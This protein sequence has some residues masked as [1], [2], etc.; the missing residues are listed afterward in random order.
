MSDAEEK[1][2][3]G[4]DIIGDTN[5]VVTNPLEKELCYRGW[6]IAGVRLGYKSAI[7]HM[8]LKGPPVS[9]LYFP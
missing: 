8:F 6:E 5:F 2:K 3:F 7:S 1:I 9:E 4:Y